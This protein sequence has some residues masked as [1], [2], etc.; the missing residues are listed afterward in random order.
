MDAI[1]IGGALGAILFLVI[2]LLKPKHSLPPGP[3]PIPILGNLRELERKG[4]WDRATSWLKEYGKILTCES[5]HAERY[6]LGDIVYLHKFG[7][8]VVFLN[9]FEV[10]YDLL[11]K[12]GLIYSDRP[13][14]VMKE[15]LCVLSRSMR[16]T[17]H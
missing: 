8:G 5:R 1:V 16:K 10:A 2:V 17:W 12:R 14:S 6:M 9:T 13:P 4:L 3:K 11:D 7:Q 15:D